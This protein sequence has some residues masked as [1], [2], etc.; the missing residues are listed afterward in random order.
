MKYVLVFL[1]LPHQSVTEQI[2]VLKTPGDLSTFRPDTGAELG[3]S[4]LS[5][6]EDVTICARFVTY[7]FTT[8][9]YKSPLQV[10]LQLGAVTLLGSY[11]MLPPPSHWHGFFR[12]SIV[13]QWQNGNVVAFSDTDGFRFFPSWHP[14]EENWNHACIIASS[15]RR[16][17]KIVVNGAVVYSGNQY[18][19]FHKKANMI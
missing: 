3:S 5:G 15:E 1:F 2:K 9:L 17:Y 10:V 4:S 19:G 8:H 16:K 6:Q 12:E 13:D 11:T 7:Q 14:G 18:N